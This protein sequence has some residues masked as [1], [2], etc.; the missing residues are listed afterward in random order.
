MVLAAVGLASNIAA[1]KAL[2]GE[3]IQRGHMRLHHRRLDE[4]SA[5]VSTAG[6]P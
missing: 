2:A 5:R 3:G 1:L 6:E 4:A